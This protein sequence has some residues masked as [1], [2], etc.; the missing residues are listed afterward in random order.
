[1]TS[2]RLSQTKELAAVYGSIAAS[3]GGNA[4]LCSWSF[5]LRPQFP[6]AL[7]VSINLRKKTK[8]EERGRETR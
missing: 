3:S 6:C 7:M 2:S 1:M 8:R 4:Q 5:V